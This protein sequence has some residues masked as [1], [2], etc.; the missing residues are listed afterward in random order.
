[1]RN[2][3]KSTVFATKYQDWLKKTGD[4]HLK[5]TPSNVHY[6][7]VVMNLFYCQHGL[8]AYTEMP[9]CDDDFY[10][11]K[12]WQNGKYMNQNKFGKFGELDHFDPSLK[13]SQG[14]LWS[15]FFMISE[16]INRDKSDKAVF[17]FLKPDEPN[18]TPF[19]W[20]EYN[21]KLNRFVPHSKFDLETE[22]NQ[23][24]Q[25][26]IDVLGLNHDTVV[27]LRRQFLTK[28]KKGIEFGMYSWDAYKP[29][30]FFTAFEFCRLSSIK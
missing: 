11:K 30:K 12:H 22:K 14:W 21:E 13:K 23:Q 24:I 2:I 20:F 8:C 17:Y 29:E 5:Y 1:M 19:D 4:I 10:D 26:M 25:Y 7:D 16:K 27:M 18:Y 15:N 3:D 28:I 6:L 9:L